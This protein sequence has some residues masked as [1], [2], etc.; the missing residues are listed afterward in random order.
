MP[1]LTSDGLGNARPY[2]HRIGNHEHF[3]L[4]PHGILNFEL[5]SKVVY[6]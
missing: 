3:R 4:L 2:H 6:G 5:W 1:G